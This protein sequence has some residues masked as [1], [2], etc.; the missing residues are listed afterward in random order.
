M[1]VGPGVLSYCDKPRHFVL[2]VRCQS[3]SVFRVDS[4]AMEPSCLEYCPAWTCADDRAGLDA[5]SHSNTDSN[6]NVL[7]CFVWTR[8]AEGRSFCTRTFSFVFEPKSRL[9]Y[10]QGRLVLHRSGS[11]QNKPSSSLPLLHESS[12][13]RSAQTQAS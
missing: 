1:S 10:E 6:M 11:Q 2:R 8:E 5:D 9:Y 12:Q 7:S 3:V 4:N 13:L